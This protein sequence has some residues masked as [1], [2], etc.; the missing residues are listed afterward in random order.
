MPEAHAQQRLV[1]DEQHARAHAAPPAPS[2]R[3]R[4]GPASRRRRAA[5]PRRRRRRPPR[6]R[7]CRAGPRPGRAGPS[8]R[9]PP[10]SVTSSSNAVRTAAQRT[11][12]CARPGVLERVGQ[13]L[14][15]DPVGGQ[16]QSG[17]QRRRGAPATLELT[18]RPAV[19]TCS[20]SCVDLG[21]CPAAA[22]A[23]GSCS[24]RST[25]SS[26]RISVSAWRPVRDAVCIAT[27]ARVWSVVHG[28]ARAVGERDHHRQVV[29]DDVVH[30]ARDAGAL[31]G[32]RQP[33]LLV[34][35]ELQPRGAL[36]QRG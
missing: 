36:L 14:L 6:A 10:A 32:G 13:R 20:S 34:A 29:R 24:S 30:L 23:R 19:R 33:A 9:P 11:R 25:P 35:L 3:S 31:G 22:P 5:R 26:R 1:V 4:A 2:G 17:R 12:R 27:S 28:E 8:A 18:G 16:L 15:D 7:A 21:R